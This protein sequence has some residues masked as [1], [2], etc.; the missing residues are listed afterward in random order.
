MAREQADNVVT[1]GERAGTTSLSDDAHAAASSWLEAARAIRCAQR[2]EVANTFVQPDR[3]G[4]TER[5]RGFESASASAGHSSF[6]H[7]RAGGVAN[8]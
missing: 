5:E 3:V 4:V 8:P 6:T 1:F 7:R 2:V